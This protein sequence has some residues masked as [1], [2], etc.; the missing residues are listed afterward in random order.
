[1]YSYSWQNW[2]LSAAFDGAWVRVTMSLL[3][4]IG[5]PVFGR[6][7]RMGDVPADTLVPAGGNG[8]LTEIR[9]F[10]FTG[11]ISRLILLILPVNRVSGPMPIPSATGV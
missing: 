8:W 11:L 6:C 1:M 4:V 3:I 9:T 10:Y 5:P 2:Q 7:G